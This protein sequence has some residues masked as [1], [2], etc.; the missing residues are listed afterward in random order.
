MTANTANVFNL[1]EYRR[2][3]GGMYV[4]TTSESHSVDVAESVAP[5]EQEPVEADPPGAGR[6]RSPAVA[7]LDRRSRVASA[8]AE[9]EDPGVIARRSANE[10]AAAREELAS[11]PRAEAFGNRRAR[12]WLLLMA[13]VGIALGVGISASTAQTTITTFMGWAAGSVA[14]LAAYG[15]DPA[16]GLVLFATLGARVLAS[17]RGVA[18]PERARRAL[19]GIETVL[20]ALVALLNAGPSL[21]R[22]VAD[23]GTGAWERIGPDFMVLV[24]HCLGPVLVA[25]GVFGIPYMALILAEV[26]AATTAKRAGTERGVTPPACSE[27]A[28]ARSSTSNPPAP[29]REDEITAELSALLAAGQWTENVAVPPIRRH[30]GVGTAVARNVRDRLAA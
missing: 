11:D 30:F 24:I 26:S 3:E 18:V 7:L 15:A 9:I 5:D 13:A 29:S 6:T 22:L 25:T 23:V 1:D 28:P 14:G 19:N 16:L 2:T 20:F 8:K 21:G 17:A 4:P 27:N 12:F 10:T